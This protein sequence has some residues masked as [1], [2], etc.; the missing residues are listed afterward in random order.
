VN[1]IQETYAWDSGNFKSNAPDTIVIHHAAAVTCTAQQ[2]HLW[3]LERGWQGFAYHYFI[4]KNGEIHTGRKENQRGGHLLDNENIN[5]LGICLEGNYD[6]EKIVPDAQL[7]ALV[8]LC[9]DIETRWKIKA[10]KKHA[11]YPSAQKEKKDCP[12]RYFPW[13]EFMKKIGDVTVIDLIKFQTAAKAIGVYTGAVD[14]KTG[15]MTRAAAQEFLPQVLQ[16]LGLKDP[17]DMQKE[18]ELMEHDIQA[19]KAPLSKY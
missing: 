10:Y 7:N 14:N 18:I 3:H 8:E 9:H 1:I 13:D 11:D 2:I 17:R 19:A 6:F 16:I 15:P 12:G 5:T 4:R